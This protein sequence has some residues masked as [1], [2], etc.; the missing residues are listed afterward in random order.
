MLLLRRPARKP[1]A[2]E[3]L[4]SFQV[5]ALILGGIVLC[6]QA[7]LRMR[8]AGGEMCLGPVEGRI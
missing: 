7:L 3:C 5:K 2:R 8:R 1:I 4:R 6:F